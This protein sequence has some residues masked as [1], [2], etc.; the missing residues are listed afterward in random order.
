[1]SVRRYLAATE[2]KRLA[3]G[4]RID[5]NSKQHE[6]IVKRELFSSKRELIFRSEKKALCENPS[7]SYVLSFLS[8]TSQSFERNIV[9]T[10]R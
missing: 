2:E 6:G 1:M 4:R 3:L 7:L 8:K 5:E 10:E 9:A